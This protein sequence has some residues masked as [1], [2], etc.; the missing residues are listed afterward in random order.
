MISFIILLSGVQTRSSLSALIYLH[1][2]SFC[3]WK[4]RL[5][6]LVNLPRSRSTADGCPTAM[7]RPPSPPALPPQPQPLYLK[8]TDKLKATPV[9]SQVSNR[10]RNFILQLADLMI[11]RVINGLIIL[12]LNMS[13]S[14]Y[15]DLPLVKVRAVLFFQLS[16]LGLNGM[17]KL[18]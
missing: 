16:S 11:Q 18:L 6:Y 2:P 3:L 14:N 4:R 7:A 1:T 15:C 10:G 9:V 17:N 12:M 5:S 8:L 13:G